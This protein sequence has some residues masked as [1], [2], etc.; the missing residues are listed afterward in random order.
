M[1]TPFAAM[2]TSVHA[3]FTVMFTPVHAPFTV[4]SIAQSARKP[5]SSR[6]FKKGRPRSLS[7]EVAASPSCKH[8]GMHL[9]FSAPLCLDVAWHSFQEG[10]GDS[11]AVLWLSILA[12]DPGVATH[13]A[14]QRSR[15]CVGAA[16]CV[17]CLGCACVRACVRACV[18]VCVCLCVW[19][20][21]VPF[22]SRAA[23][24]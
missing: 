10:S 23:P 19:C 24:Q 6:T 13:T 16:N 2:F 11:S 8:N 20:V 7:L 5:L 4:C 14:Q 15:L 21:C 17:L 1:N 9:C 18:S 12:S 22:R 3:P